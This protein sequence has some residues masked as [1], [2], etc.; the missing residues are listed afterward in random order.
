MALYC[1]AVSVIL[2]GL[3]ILC[4]GEMINRPTEYNEQNGFD[5]DLSVFGDIGK[6]Y[7]LWIYAITDEVDFE[8]DYDDEYESGDE[9]ILLRPQ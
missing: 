4:A 5:I 9:E 3:Y 8:I 7:S 1:L 6:L 2:L